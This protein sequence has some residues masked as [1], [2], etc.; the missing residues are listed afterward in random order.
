[1]IECLGNVYHKGT[2][3][4]KAFLL[5]ASGCS[6]EFQNDIYIMGSGEESFIAYNLLKDKVNIKGM[7]D[8][9]TAI[10]GKKSLCGVPYRTVREVYSEK[11]CI[12]VAT[13]RKHL[14]NNRWQL[15]IH[16]IDNY[17]LFF[18]NE[19]ADIDSGEQ[20][21]MDAINKSVF[22]NGF[23]HDL[24]PVNNVSALN[25]Y[26]LSPI[27]YLLSS[28]CMWHPGFE[29]LIKM[30]QCNSLLEIGPGRGI[31]TYMLTQI[32][33]DISNVD[34][35]V[36]ESHEK[37]CLENQEYYNIFNALV[38]CG[39][40]INILKGMIEKP[41]YNIEKKYDLIVMT[42]VI[43][44]FTTNP[45]NVIKKMCSWL[46]KKGVICISTPDYSPLHIYEHLDEMPEYNDDSEMF[47]YVGHTY[48][49]RKEELDKIFQMEGLEV[50]LYE[51]SMFGH[52]NY[53]LQKA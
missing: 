19:C 23:E 8:N 31:F 25:Q 16:G 40:H 49:Y 46:N 24:P 39:V 41:S 5:N 22:I 7:I 37:D 51:K 14:N 27:D 26:F 34:W 47:Y 32:N 17:C 42:E 6:I 33:R 20:Y 2:I 28:T 53:I 10:K 3:N 30:R 4:Y 18:I 43:E 12:V 13:P 15:L 21:V 9:N 44:H 36:Y 50:L 35:C 52:H 48:Q 29:Y 1:M 38:Q 11:S 45:Q